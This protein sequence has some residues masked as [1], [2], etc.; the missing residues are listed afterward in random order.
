MLQRLTQFHSACLEESWTDSIGAGCF[1][2]AQSP[3]LSCDLIRRDG[4]GEGGALCGR[5]GEGCSYVE[6]QRAGSWREWGHTG[7]GQSRGRGG[8]VVA[9]REQLAAATARESTRME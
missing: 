9:C 4:G 6:W 7:C 3:Q 8:V 2:G 1:P 5:L